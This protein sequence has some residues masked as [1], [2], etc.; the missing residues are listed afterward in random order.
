MGTT[1]RVHLSKNRDY[2]SKVHA[3]LWQKYSC[4]NNN[5][6]KKTVKCLLLKTPKNKLNHPII[7]GFTEKI[8]SKESM[9]R[10]LY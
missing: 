1:S 3:L 5:L 8:L 10:S 9:T 7:E 2:W 4:K 6:I